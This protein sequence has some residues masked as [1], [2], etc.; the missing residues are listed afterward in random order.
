[1]IDYCICVVG[2]YKV[3]GELLSLAATEQRLVYNVLTLLSLF[4][5]DDESTVVFLTFKHKD[6]FLSSVFVGSLHSKL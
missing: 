2:G 3:C 5:G 1:M 4:F 6:L